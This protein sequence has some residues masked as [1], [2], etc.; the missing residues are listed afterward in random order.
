MCRAID[1]SLEDFRRAFWRGRIRA[2]KSWALQGQRM[3][4]GNADPRDRSPLF[5]AVAFQWL[6][7]LA[8]MEPEPI[9]LFLIPL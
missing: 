2:I 9:F 1:N 4:P 3:W 8:L 5:P 6:F 7:F